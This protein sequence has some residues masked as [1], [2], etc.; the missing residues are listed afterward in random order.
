[1][2]LSAPDGVAE[3][4]AQIEFVASGQIAEDRKK[5]LKKILK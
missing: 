2:E 5:E 3:I 4:Q 1:M